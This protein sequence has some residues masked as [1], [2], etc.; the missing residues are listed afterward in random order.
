MP[1]QHF[2]KAYLVTE[3]IEKNSRF[4]TILTSKKNERAVLAHLKHGQVRNI[5]VQN[6]QPKKH[7]LFS[8][9]QHAFD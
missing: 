9:I 3:K 1:V 6:Y 7:S 5:Q 8:F 4:S 2:K